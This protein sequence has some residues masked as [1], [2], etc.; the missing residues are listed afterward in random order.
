MKAL[1]ASTLAV[2]AILA[3]ASGHATA[4]MPDVKQMSG[5]PLPVGDVAPASVA[6]R[7]VRGALTNV[8]PNQPVDLVGGAAPV[9]VKTNEEGRAEFTG[10][11]PGTR[12]RAVTTVDGERIES[13]EFGVPKTGGIRLLLVASDPAGAVRER[14]P[15]AV[16]EPPLPEAPP[17]PGTVVLGGE[18]RFVFEIGEDGL[19]VFN[20]LQVVNTQKSPVQ[21]AP[22]VF[23]LP[24]A[25]EHA[26]VL[27]GS[28]S[29]A[30]VA[31][32]RVTI[33]GPF[34]PGPTVVQFAYTLPIRGS[35]MTV[36]QTVPAALTQLTVLVQ[37][38]GE[39]H[40]TSEQFAQHRDMSTDGQAYILGQGPALEAGDTITLALTG[41]PAA[42]VWPR[43]LAL[44]LA[45]II[46]VAGGWMAARPRRAIADAGHRARQLQAR[47]DRLFGQLT[48]LEKQ[49]TAGAVDTDRYAAR[50]RELVSALERVYEELDEHAAA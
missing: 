38:I 3:I 36:R 49:H 10:L 39:M 17:Q 1:V 37:R 42:S 18:S 32:K 23:E 25:A 19:N 2:C 14:P 20:I 24:D 35:E 12:V 43:N 33:S 6:V 22:L 16:L 15:G 9:T 29:H 5:V 48:E 40:V 45:V 4:Q 7:V 11:T 8:I 44:S 28:S 21:T 13:L 27:E 30:V 50:R 26:S 41:L 31:G 34:A 46:L 47:R